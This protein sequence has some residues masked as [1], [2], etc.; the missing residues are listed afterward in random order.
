[1]KSAWQAFRRRL[2]ADCP[3]YSQPMPAVSDESG[4][5][6]LGCPCTHDDC[7]YGLLENPADE[8]G[9]RSVR[10]CPVCM[11]DLYQAMSELGATGLSLCDD[12]DECGR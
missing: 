7:D 5:G 6:K 4:C 8:G 1:M 10:P 3:G 12:Q 9:R 2:T 11:P